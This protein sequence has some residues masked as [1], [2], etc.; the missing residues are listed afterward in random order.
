[1][2][3]VWLFF[4]MILCAG[5]YYEYTVLEQ[6]ITTDEQQVSDLNTKLNALQS[7]NKKLADD[8]GKLSKTA[9]DAQAAVSDLTG[10]LQSTQTA[11]T[12]AQA[13]A[14]AAATVASSAGAKPPQP[15]NKLGTITTLDGKTFQNCQLLKVKAD[16]IVVNDSEGITE[17]QY[18]FLPPDLQKRFGYD[19]HVAP[20]LT[21]D[22]IQY[23]EQLRQAAQTAGN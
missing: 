16:G 8:N 17:I 2:N 11:L 12:Q 18:A 22:Q 9:N 23:Q 10:Q 4:M 20:Q 19:I 3:Y 5:G 6:K 13:K 1:M 7:E 15:G 21:D 14:Q